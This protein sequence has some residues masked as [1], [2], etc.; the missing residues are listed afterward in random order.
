MAKELTDDEQN[1]RRKARRRLI[2]ASALT[3]AVVVILPMVLDSEPKPN[4]QD[5]DLRIP[6]PDK[7]GEFVPGV[8][9]SEVAE[10]LPLAGSA[11]AP[12]SAVATVSAPAAI[13]A[14]AASPVAAVEIVK[15]V[16]N[17]I[18]GNVS[19]QATQPVAKVAEPKAEAKSE[20]K[21]GS[22]GYAA[23]VGA[24]SNAATAKQEL[25]KLK[26]WGFK[27]YTEKAGNKIRVRVGPYDERDKVVK[28]AKLLEKHGLHPSIVS[29][30]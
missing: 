8:A 10:A 24:Y 18:K 2:G 27:A 7:V 22:A 3:L 17:E 16:V 23:Q 1:L 21:Q 30:K 19:N 12:A 26:K 25:D 29:A 11:V 20:G 13:P 5:I 9:V 28:V 6:N 15:P 14:V 4:T